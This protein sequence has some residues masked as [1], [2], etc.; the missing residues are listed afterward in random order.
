MK[1][2]EIQM[3]EKESYRERVIKSLRINLIFTVIL[4]LVA[5]FASNWMY[6]V[7]FGVILFLV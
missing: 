2:L 7:G 5:A 1:N 6:A 3:V 4:S